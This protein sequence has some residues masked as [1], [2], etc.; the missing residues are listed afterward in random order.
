[1][2]VFLFCL[3]LNT[4]IGCIFVGQTSVKM[5]NF[6]KIKENKQ[7]NSTTIEN[8]TTS[9]PPALSPSLLLTFN[10]LSED[11]KRL[12]LQIFKYL[13][14]RVIPF[15]RFTGTGGIL[16]SYWAIE[17]LRYHSGLTAWDLSILSYIYQATKQGKKYIHS[18]NLY[19]KS[20]LLNTSAALLSDR[21]SLLKRSG[22]LVRSSF[23][24]AR[25]YNPGLK[26]KQFINVSLKGVRLIEDFERDLYKILVNNCLDD[27]KGTNKKP[28]K[29]PRLN[30]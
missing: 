24:P 13:W 26:Q 18:K 16:H 25:S 6:V 29:C 30:K 4:L 7:M 28:R 10:S 5:F 1:M 27:L 15:T 19:N 12:F 11:D 23:D 2:P 8:L 20:E 14:G 22:Y 9:G 21:L 3:I 17:F